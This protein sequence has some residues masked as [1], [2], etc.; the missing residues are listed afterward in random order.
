MGKIESKI[1]EI[2]EDILERVESFGEV[3]LL[4]GSIYVVIYF[5]GYAIR[6]CF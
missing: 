1:V 4:L 5:V 2:L 3:V 6:G